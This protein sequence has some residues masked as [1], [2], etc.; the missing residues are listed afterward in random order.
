[1]PIAITDSVVTVSK[2]PGLLR[3]N[4]TLRV[5]IA[6][7]ISVWVASDSTNQPVR[8]STA[9]ACRT[10]SINPNVRK[11]NSELMG[12]NVSMKRRMNATFQCEGL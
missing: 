10:P 8:N 5:R 12:P 1:M 2:P 7:M 4:G 3:K 9:P 11:S 6:K